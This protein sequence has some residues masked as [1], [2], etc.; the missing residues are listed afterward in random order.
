MPPG[1]I[2]LED[3]GALASGLHDT[4]ARLIQRQ[5]GF[6]SRTKLRDE[7][8]LLTRVVVSG[9]SRGSAVLDCDVLPIEGLGGRHPSAVAAFDLVN[10]IK[11]FSSAQAWPAYFPAVARNR[12]GAAAAPVLSGK[13]QDTS[14][15]I[16]V[17][18][19]GERAT[20]RID[21]SIRQALQTPEEFSPDQP[22]EVVGD[23]FNIDINNKTFKID[24]GRKYVTVH[25]EAGRLAEVDALRWKRVFVVGYS[26]D[27]A[28]RA[29]HKFKICG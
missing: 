24:L 1:K 17:E 15:L 16:T 27:E 11:Y 22:V 3:A 2:L 26:Y 28:C 4:L 23:I 12:I 9:V 25:I 13:S 8:K 5:M 21:Q 7:A 18:E 19:D 10:G 6:P 29:I 14:I 20:C